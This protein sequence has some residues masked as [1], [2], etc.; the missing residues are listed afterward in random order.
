MIEDG[1]GFGNP[2]YKA[3]RIL[4]AE[5][6]KALLEA[7]PKLENVESMFRKKAMELHEASEV[8][9]VT[10]DDG[11]A[12]SA[13]LILGCDRAHSA[14]RRF[15]DP[16]CT[17]VYSSIAVAYGFARIRDKLEVP[18]KD[19]SLISFRRGSQAGR[20]STLALSWKWQKWSSVQTKIWPGETSKG[21]LVVEPCQS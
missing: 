8:A 9:N 17:P 6:I 4:R 12:A 1:K 7:L 18:W 19:T 16:D 3:L 15:V 5:L 11:S 14:A 21:G 10:F 13:D 2:P 20:I